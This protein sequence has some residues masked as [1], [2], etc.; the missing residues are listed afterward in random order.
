M[1]LLL[2]VPHRERYVTACTA[3]QPDRFGIGAQ[4]APASP[5]EGRRTMPTYISMLTWT[6]D[7]QPRPADVRIAILRHDA[8]LR[9]CGL[10][11]VALLPDEGACGAV[12]VATADDE[13]AAGRLA[14]SILPRATIRIESMRFDDEPAGPDGTREVV[15]PPP[16][17]DYLKAVLEAVATG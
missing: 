13:A 16:P 1:H 5:A 15:C 9:A 12:M 4:D 3:V 7:P 14:A 6:G 10:H 2:D 11:S 8:S 17:R